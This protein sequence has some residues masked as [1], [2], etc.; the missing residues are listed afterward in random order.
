MLQCATVACGLGL[1]QHLGGP[2]LYGPLDLGTT[3]G[4]PVQLAG[5]WCAA[6]RHGGSLAA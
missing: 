3:P 4:Q 5:Q 2:F 1:R 6:A